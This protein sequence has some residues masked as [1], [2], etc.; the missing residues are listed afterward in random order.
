MLVAKVEAAE[1][2]KT[3]IHSMTN[4]SMTT[5]GLQSAWTMVVDDPVET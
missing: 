5:V 3:H 1:V 4:S 2:R